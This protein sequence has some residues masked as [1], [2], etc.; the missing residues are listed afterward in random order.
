MSKVL[1]YHLD[2]EQNEQ[3]RS[4]RANPAHS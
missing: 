4:P 1:R 2:H 3:S